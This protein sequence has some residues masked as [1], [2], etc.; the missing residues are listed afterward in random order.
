MLTLGT[1]EAT[2]GM[3]TDWGAAGWGHD[4]PPCKPVFVALQWWPEHVIAKL[5]AVWAYLCYCVYW[6]K[7]GCTSCHELLHGSANVWPTVF[8]M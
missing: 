8:S 4:G 6:L 2:Y 1:L 5:A 7:C 3:L